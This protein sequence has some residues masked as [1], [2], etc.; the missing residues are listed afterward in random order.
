MDS[1]VGWTMPRKSHAST[2]LLIYKSWMFNLN[3]VIIT[4]SVFVDM[5]LKYLWNQGTSKT[6]VFV[7][8]FD[9]LKL[10]ENVRMFRFILTDSD[11]YCVQLST[12]CVGY[13]VTA[14]RAIKK[15][16]TA[17]IWCWCS[18]GWMDPAVSGLHGPG[19][20]SP[21]EGPCIML[22]CV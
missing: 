17:E 16:F 21:G 5:R 14:F 11:V 2:V 6:E 9:M 19:P 13:K 1:G 22:L 15:Y 12:L 18:W 7:N 8:I 20:C 4:C 3:D 10:R